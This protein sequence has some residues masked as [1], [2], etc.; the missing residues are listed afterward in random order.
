MS[1]E[2]GQLS[3]KGDGSAHSLDRM[4]MRRRWIVTFETGSV[5]FTSVLANEA[6]AR[7]WASNLPD[8]P[9]CEKITKV[10][11]EAA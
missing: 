3:A 8:T 11:W 7:K 4:V 1:A 10:R 2:T 5:S 6:F 9:K